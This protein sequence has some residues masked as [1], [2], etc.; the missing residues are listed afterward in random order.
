MERGHIVTK[1]HPLILYIHLRHY[2][3]IILPVTLLFRVYPYLCR[4]VRN[5]ARDRGEVNVTK[6][7]YVAFEDVSTRHK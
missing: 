3:L 2:L 7:F 6:E 1:P 4:A 5:F